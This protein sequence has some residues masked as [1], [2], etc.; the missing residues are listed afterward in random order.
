MDESQ[1]S[2]EE[3]SQTGLKYRELSAKKTRRL[4]ERKANRELVKA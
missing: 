4:K 1:S 2:D 3:E